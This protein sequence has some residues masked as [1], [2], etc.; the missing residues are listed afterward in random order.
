MQVLWNHEA[1][2]RDHTCMGCVDCRD[3]ISARLDGEDLPGESE[4]IDAHVAS[5][6]DCSRYADR[7]ARITRLTRTRAAE[8]SPDL[9]AV[10]LDAAPPTPRRRLH[11]GPVRLALGVVGLGQCALAINGILAVGAHHGVVELAGA[12]AA[13][14]SH[15]SSAWNLALAIG[16]LWV[17]T[18]TARPAGLVPLVGA[19]VGVLTVLSVLDVLRGGVDPSRLWTHGL[20]VLGFVLLLLLQRITRHGGGG[21]IRSG[22]LDRQLAEHRPPEGVLRSLHGGQDE[23]NGGLQPTAHG[24][25]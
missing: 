19:F 2:T 20:I 12:S 22:P 7:A 25:A 5:C 23:E 14:L 10:V 18:G 16:F 8:S 24:A 6:A 11:P 3:A 4:A 15:E 13:H 17:A 9:V 1:A 21:A